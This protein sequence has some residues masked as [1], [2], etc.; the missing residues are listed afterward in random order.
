MIWIEIS[1]SSLWNP[2]LTLDLTFGTNFLKGWWSFLW[3]SGCHSGTNWLTG[4]FPPSIL[5][6][7]VL[8]TLN[9][10]KIH[11][12][13]WRL[14]R[15]ISGHMAH[16]KHAQSALFVYSSRYIG[17][18]MAASMTGLAVGFVLLSLRETNIMS[19]ELAQALLTFN[20]TNFFV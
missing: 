9:L 3:Y 13:N 14:D 6:F 1:P 10:R 11:V 4:I 12:N 20:H 2:W 17:E 15:H 18:G 5:C 7:N 8:A 16:I 19:A